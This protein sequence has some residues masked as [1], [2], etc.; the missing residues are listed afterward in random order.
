MVT[1]FRKTITVTASSTKQ[2]KITFPRKAYIHM[3][4]VIVSGSTLYDFKLYSDKNYT[5]ASLIY[6]AEDE[7]GDLFDFSLPP[8]QYYKNEEKTDE[9]YIE[10]TEKSGNNGTFLIEIHATPIETDLKLKEG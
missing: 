8:G 2:D 1:I 5:T 3:I 6:E 7:T 9:L 10:I 4:K